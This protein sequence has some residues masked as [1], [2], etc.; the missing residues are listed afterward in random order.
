MNTTIGINGRKDA[1]HKGGALFSSCKRIGL[2]FSYYIFI[3]LFH[4]YGMYK[5]K[6][7]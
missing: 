3:L 6:Y 5:C 2:D 4:Q 1:E 7:N